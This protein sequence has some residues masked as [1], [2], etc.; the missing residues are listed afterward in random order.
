MSYAVFPKKIWAYSLLYA[1]R[2]KCV[3][4]SKNETEQNQKRLKITWKSV[5]EGV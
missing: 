5:K 4:S 2:K 3:Q 1:V